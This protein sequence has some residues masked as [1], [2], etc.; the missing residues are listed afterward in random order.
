MELMTR[1]LT[2]DPRLVRAVRNIVVIAMAVLLACAVLSSHHEQSP[3]SAAVISHVEASHASGASVAD[4][5]TDTLTTATAA[6]GGC[7]LLVL[8]C[9]LALA[10][11]RRTWRAALT[12]ATRQVEPLFGLLRLLTE[13]GSSARMTPRPDLVSLSISRT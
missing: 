1:P 13:A 9:I 10:V 12:T 8:C 7:V 6:V 3:V 2:T 11:L 5:V 4:G